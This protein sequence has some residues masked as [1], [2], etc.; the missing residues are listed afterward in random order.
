MKDKTILITGSAKRIGRAIAVSM[1]KHGWNIAI[2]YNN[3]Q[4]DAEDTLNEIKA[5]GVKACLVQADL[6]HEAQLNTIFP[7]VN[8]KI[9]PV[10]CLINNASVFKN[11][12]IQNV[13]LASW[14]ENLGINLYAPIMLIQK[15]TE[16]LPDT[17]TGN[18]INMLDYIVWRYPEKFLSY[19]T[20]KAGLWVLTQQLA[21]TL[22][23]KIRINAIGPGRTLPSQHENLENFHKSCESSPLAIGADPDEICRAVHFIL[24]SPSMTGQ[25]LALDG[26]KHLVG[27]EAY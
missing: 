2:H 15:F 24:S 23:P 12:T 1:A 9:G 7:Q 19:T 16:Q 27:P 17:N 14:H 25:M 18:I 10:S 11:D 22:A 20:S 8:A 5:L 4:A 21:L 3:S 6:T 26:G 13:T